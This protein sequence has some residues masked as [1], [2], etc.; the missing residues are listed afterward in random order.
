MYARL[1]PCLY[2]VVKVQCPNT[3]FYVSKLT[4]KL[5]GSNLV[6]IGHPR[7]EKQERR[8]GWLQ[9]RKEMERKERERKEGEGIFPWSL[10][11]EIDNI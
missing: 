1:Q 10:S 2:F 3:I 8:E 9:E 4:L 7:L 6:K 11:L 5:K